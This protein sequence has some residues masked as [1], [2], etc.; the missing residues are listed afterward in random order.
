M[1]VGNEMGHLLA[2]LTRAQMIPGKVALA[3]ANDAADGR[4]LHCLRCLL[5]V[6]CCLLWLH[7]WLRVLAIERRA[8]DGKDD[9]DPAPPRLYHIAAVPPTA[10]LTAVETRDG[11][12]YQVLS[13]DRPRCGTSTDGLRGFIITTN[14]NTLLPHMPC[15][16]SPCLCLCSYVLSSSRNILIRR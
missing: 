16:S 4:C 8:V 7:G 5:C 1:L 15:L 9:D 2:S 11:G 13:C 3:D 14:S 6:R 10:T 12:A